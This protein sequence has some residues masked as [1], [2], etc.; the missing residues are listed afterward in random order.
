[1]AC[2]KALLLPRLDNIVA[3]FF[4]LC[5]VIGAL[6]TFQQALKDTKVL[7]D[8]HRNNPKIQIDQWQMQ[9]VV[10]FLLPMIAARAVSICLSAAN[11]EPDQLAWCG[12]GLLTSGLLLSML[13]PKRTCFIGVCQKCKH[14]VPIVFVEF[15]SC[16]RCDDKLREKIEPN[17]R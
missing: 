17:A 10:I 1:M 7:R 11:T 8:T 12:T 14:P 4:L 16:P 6:K 13:K 2:V 15:G 9:L 5:L 3:L